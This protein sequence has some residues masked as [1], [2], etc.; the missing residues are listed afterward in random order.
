[1]APIDGL[2]ETV[3]EVGDTVEA[4]ALAAR[5]W[6]MDDLARAP[7]EVRFAEAGM[8]MATRTMPMVERGDTICHTGVAMSDEEFLC[9]SR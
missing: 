5:V 8:V 1:M 3:V 9:G 6:P 4:G 2:A 7:V